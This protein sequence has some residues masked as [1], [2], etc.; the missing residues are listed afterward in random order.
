MGEDLRDLQKVL[1]LMGYSER[2]VKEILKWY[3]NSGLWAEGCGERGLRS[4][5][6]GQQKHKR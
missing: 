3:E 5:D 4:G 2:A 1:R 6:S